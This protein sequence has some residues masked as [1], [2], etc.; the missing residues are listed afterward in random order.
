LN[1]AFLDDNRVDLEVIKQLT[2]RFFGAKNCM[3]SCFDNVSEFMSA[4]PASSYDLIFLDIV[5]NDEN[6][7][8]I[9]EKLNE[10]S[11]DSD[12]VFISGYPQYFQDVYRARHS[13]FLTKPLDWGR[14]SEAM[15]RI[16]KRNETGML[17]IHTKQ[18]LERIPYRSILYLESV[19]KHTILHMKDGSKPDFSIQLQKVENDLPDTMFVRI[20]KSYIVNVRHIL[21]YNSR[22]IEVEGGTQLPIG[23]TFYTSAR[24]R[25]TRI[26]SEDV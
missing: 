16:M 22:F 24:E 13:W 9:G 23:R 2:V 3:L 1:I 18:G 11:P 26:L 20:H 15:S 12:I 8:Q 7:I 17:G 5:L 19:L 10:L 4:L 6:G 25:L 14:F 21:K